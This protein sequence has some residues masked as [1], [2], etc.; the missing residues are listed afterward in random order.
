MNFNGAKRVD[1]QNHS[2][3]SDGV[4]PP[5]ELLKHA[6][7]LGLGGIALTEH[8]YANKVESIVEKL[9]Q[10]EKHTRA[11]GIIFIPGAE[12]SLVPP[13]RICEIARRAKE[14]GARFVTVHGESLMGGTPPGTNLAS[15]QCE[16]VDMI[17]HP[18]FLS[19]KA[20][21]CAARNNISIELSGRALHSL[22]NGH[23]AKL[24][25]KYG[26]KL[27]VNSDTHKPEDLMTMARAI[28]V[29]RGAGLDDEEV[30]RAIVTNAEELLA[31]VT[32]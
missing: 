23:N 9:L 3:L 10:V 30:Y 19:D 5:I 18:G 4:L 24:A 14:A 29:A 7:K 16:Y 2:T 27:L 12:V 11:L 1:F 28:E 31:R 25:L 32:K 22:T 20:A 15:A 8:V 17:G 13:D 26:A 6:K 21:Q